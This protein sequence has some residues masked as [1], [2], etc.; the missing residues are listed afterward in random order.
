MQ[1]NRQTADQHELDVA[2]RQQFDEIEH[3]HDVTLTH[4]SAVFQLVDRRSIPRGK[5]RQQGRMWMLLPRGF[6]PDSAK[7]SAAN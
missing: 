7:N 3:D 6:V 5:M 2:F 4:P 1:G